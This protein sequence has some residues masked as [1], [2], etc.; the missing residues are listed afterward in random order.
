MIANSPDR[1]DVES[2]RLT[3]ITSQ[4]VAAQGALSDSQAKLRQLRQSGEDEIQ[5]AP[6]IL[7]TGCYKA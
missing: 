1:L 6:D 5:Q 4:L 7:E 2:A 3:D